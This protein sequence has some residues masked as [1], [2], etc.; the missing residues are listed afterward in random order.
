MFSGAKPPSNLEYPVNVNLNKGRTRR[1]TAGS[2]NVPK[3]STE[4]PKK[5]SLDRVKRLVQLNNSL[6]RVPV[7]KKPPHNPL[8]AE[9]GIIDLEEKK[10]PPSHSALSEDSRV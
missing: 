5:L 8:A 10:N 2:S 7:R 4:E 1:N 9:Y 3:P 6:S